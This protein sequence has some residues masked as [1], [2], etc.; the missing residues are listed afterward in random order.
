MVWRSLCLKNM[1]DK[2]DNT[3]SE[4]TLS[5]TQSTAMRRL[6]RAINKWEMLCSLFVLSPA[7]R[8]SIRVEVHFCSMQMRK[9]VVK[10]WQRLVESGKRGNHNCLQLCASIVV[11]FNGNASL[12]LCVMCV[13]TSLISVTQHE[14]KSRASG[15]RRISSW[16][17]ASVGGRQR[18]EQTIEIPIRFN[19]RFI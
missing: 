12:V 18:S 15:Q 1:T 17:E 6:C 10:E 7:S 2:W 19:A 4:S 5:T 11:L 13:P 16:S 14:F 8:A 9:R 3:L